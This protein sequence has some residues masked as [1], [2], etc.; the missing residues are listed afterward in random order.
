MNQKRKKILKTFFLLT[1]ICESTL[2]SIRD[3]CSRTGRAIFLIYIFF[4]G[5]IAK[6]DVIRPAAWRIARIVVIHPAAGRIASATNVGLNLR[7]EMLTQVMTAL[8]N[9]MYIYSSWLPECCGTRAFFLFQKN[10]Q[11]YLGTVF[12]ITLVISVNLVRQGVPNYANYHILLRANTTKIQRAQYQTDWFNEF[13]TLLYHHASF[14]QPTVTISPERSF[15]HRLI[16]A[17]NFLVNR[18][19]FFVVAGPHG[20]IWS[21]DHAPNRQDFCY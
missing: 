11:F 5:R 16:A 18:G 1:T 7:T 17:N 4:A 6:L 9:S 15:R 21:F 14:G 3:E 19:V 10:I 2:K 8:I 13:Q 12:R 20:P